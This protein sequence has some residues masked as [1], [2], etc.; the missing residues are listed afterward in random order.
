VKRLP[1]RQVDRYKARVVARGFSQQY[2]LDYYE[3]FASVVR[4]ESL[5]I[6]L[7]IAA[8]EDLEIHQIDVITAYLAEEL[9]EEIYIALPQS[10]SG[11]TQKV[12]RLKKR[13]YGLKQSAR[14]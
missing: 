2:S 6:L 13:L 7:V 4:M 10:L 3:T 11:A 1:N 5:C 8:Q 14:V 9:Q 12:C